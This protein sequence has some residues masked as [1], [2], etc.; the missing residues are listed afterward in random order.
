[1]R[2]KK[3]FFICLSALL[4]LTAGCSAPG[5]NH[6][7]SPQSTSSGGE[8]SSKVSAE[9]S[10]SSAADAGS[11][12][13]SDHSDWTA[14]IDAVHNLC[15]KKKGDASGKVI[16]K[17]VMEAPCVAGEWVYYLPNLD[18]ID[19]VKLDGSQKAKVCSTDAFQVYNANLNASHEINGSTSVTAKYQDGYILYKCFQLKEEGDKK[20]NPPSYYK[21]NLSQNKLTPVKNQSN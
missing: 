15:I 2:F 11:K 5:K 12:A 7:A 10:T 13:S 21:L 19:K 9:G 17:D 16:V 14:Y 4:I 8:T 6:A 18:E 3:V 20:S 1:M